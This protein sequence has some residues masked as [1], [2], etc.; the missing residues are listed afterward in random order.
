MCGIAGYFSKNLRFLAHLEVSMRSISHRGPD[1]S[2]T[3]EDRAAGIGL[4]HP[5]GHPGSFSS[6][7]SANAKS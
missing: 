7:A 1:D 3:F 5:A 6:R 2:D 4:A